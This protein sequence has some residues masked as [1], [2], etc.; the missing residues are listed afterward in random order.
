MTTFPGLL[1][2]HWIGDF[3]YQSRE[4][5]ENKSKSNVVLARHVLGYSWVFISFA[6]LDVCIFNDSSF[7]G[8][9]WMQ[10][11]TT[12][13]LLHFVTDYFTSRMTTKAYQAGDMKRFWNII[14]IDQCIHTVCLYLTYRAL[15]GMA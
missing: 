8:I 7:T 10:F 2:G 9:Q 1:V 3:L 6:F 11:I 14:G 13:A 15:G 12:N 4:V 5:A